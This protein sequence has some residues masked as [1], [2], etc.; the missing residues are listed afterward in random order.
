MKSLFA[1]FLLLLMAF[2]VMFVSFDSA[3]AQRR[4]R[5]RNYSKGDV[6]AII[7]RVENR[8]DQFQRAIDPARDRSRRD[9]S[10]REDQVNELAKRLENTL[11]DLRREFDRRENYY[12]TRDEVSRALQIASNINRTMRNRRLGRNAESA[13]HALRY[14]LNTLAG[15][16][17]LP[18]V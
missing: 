1:K 14:D 3:Q 4:A 6:D 11:D 10:R 7:K 5:G 12:D 17:N 8:S 16:Y 15:V 2:G 18:R 9:G 13:W